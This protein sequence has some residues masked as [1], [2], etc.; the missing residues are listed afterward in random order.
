MKT[1]ICPLFFSVLFLFSVSL[2]GQEVKRSFL[3]KTNQHSIDVQ[4][5][6]IG[7]SYA[8]KFKPNLTLGIGAHFR[9]GVQIILLASPITYNF[10]FSDNDVPNKFRP[11]GYS[12]ELLKL[13]L[14][15]RNALSKHFYFDAGPFYSIVLFES[16]WDNVYNAGIETTLKYMYWKMSIGVR[17]RVAYSFD[18]PFDKVHYHPEKSYFA[19]FLTPLVIGFNF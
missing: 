11:T 7:Y 18:N 10:G 15:Y 5:A 13:Q 17:L 4:F 19:L 3:N 16:E 6:S 2:S 12:F 9:S 14:F 8:H 1:R